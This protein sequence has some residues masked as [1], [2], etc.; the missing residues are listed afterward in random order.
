MTLPF[1]IRQKIW[2]S[3]IY[4]LL[5]QA[6]GGRARLTFFTA[7]LSVIF[8]AHNR[9]Q[10]RKKSALYPIWVTYSHKVLIK[11]SLKNCDHQYAQ[12]FDLKKDFPLNECLENFCNVL[13]DARTLSICGTDRLYRTACFE[14]AK[15]TNKYL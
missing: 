12:T 7:V 10:S 14:V 15:I 2:C 11:R 5:K 9:A 8:L 1:I 4:A 6:L 3:Q 13:L